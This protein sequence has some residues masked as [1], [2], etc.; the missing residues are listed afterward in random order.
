MLLDD[1]RMKLR[2]I[3]ESTGISKIRVAYILHEQLDMKY[4]AQ[5]GYRACSQQ[6]KNT[7]A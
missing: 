5:D 3:A 6:I 2:E 7:L 4:F 1:W